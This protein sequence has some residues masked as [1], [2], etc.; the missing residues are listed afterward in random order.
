MA[1]AVSSERAE[2]KANTLITM[3]IKDEAKY[4]VNRWLSDGKETNRITGIIQQRKSVNSRG[5]SGNSSKNK[6]ILY[7]QRS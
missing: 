7:Q 1:E 6:R 3:K 2:N 4:T 5:T